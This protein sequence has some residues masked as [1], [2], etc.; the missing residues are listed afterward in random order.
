MCYSIV[1]DSE[2]TIYCRP[3]MCNRKQPGFHIRWKGVVY[4]FV[5]RSEQLH[6]D[7]AEN[8]LGGLRNYKITITSFAKEKYECRCNN[9]SRNRM[10]FEIYQSPKSSLAL[11]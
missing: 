5:A 11:W 8:I 3:W 7:S 10:S 4:T 2:R 6:R 9:L 1:F